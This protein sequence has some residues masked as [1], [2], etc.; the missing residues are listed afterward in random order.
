MTIG[1]YF[2]GYL[3]DV[4]VYVT[5]KYTS[6]FTMWTNTVNTVTSGIALL[7]DA[8]N[9]SSYPGT[10]TT[11]TDLSGNGYNGTLTNGPT[12]SS[13]NS[14]YIAFDGSNDV[15]TGS[16][17]TSLFTGAHT[18]TCWFYR[19][20]V[21]DWSGL[22]SNNT[23]VYSSSILGFISSSNMVGINQAGVNATAI[24]VDLGSDHLNKWI[25]CAIVFAGA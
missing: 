22:F 2:T 4:R 25:Y 16:I 21:T 5:A 15:V 10:G 11:W 19:L 3:T 18:I 24:S 12:Y 8:G 9:T 20:S 6:P 23:T 14:G 1:Q 13:N 17:A 7:L